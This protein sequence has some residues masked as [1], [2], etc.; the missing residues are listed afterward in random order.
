MRS[1]SP[2]PEARHLAEEYHF[3][4]KKEKKKQ[5]QR[6]E[7]FASSAIGDSTT[8]CFVHDSFA[9]RVV[10]VR[11]HP[12]H[13]WPGASGGRR[14]VPTVWAHELQLR[15]LGSLLRTG[16]LHHRK[17]TTESRW[18]A[19]MGDS[20]GRTGADRKSFSQVAISAVSQRYQNARLV[21]L[22]SAFSAVAT[23]S[24]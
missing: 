14:C 16:L 19:F 9:I 2:P 13:Q 7:A 20:K 11:Y 22:S 4:C 6:P 3:P 5:A 10:V 18:V 15:E 23:P 24:V 17:S 8:E 1:S 12:R 21:L